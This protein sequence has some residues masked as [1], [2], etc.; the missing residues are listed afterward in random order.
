MA[1]GE[2]VC[3]CVGGGGVLISCGMY[4]WALISGRGELKFDGEVL[5]SG[6][7]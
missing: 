3:V 6:T 7:F 2:C 4:I 1:E 5:L